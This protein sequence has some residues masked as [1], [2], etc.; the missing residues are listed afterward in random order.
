MNFVVKVV[1]DDEMW[2]QA[3]RI[4]VYGY[5]FAAVPLGLLH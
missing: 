5:H 3:K 2:L 4:Q 1:T